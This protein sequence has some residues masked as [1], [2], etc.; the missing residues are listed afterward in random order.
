MA[1]VGQMSVLAELDVTAL[2]DY[3][4]VFVEQLATARARTPHPQYPQIEEV[5]STQVQRAFSGEVSVEEALTVAAEQID[6][7]LATS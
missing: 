5:L 2:N 6:D 3:Y 1:K 4:D 7:L